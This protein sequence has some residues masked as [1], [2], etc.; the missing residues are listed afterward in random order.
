M[1]SELYP[2]M[3]WKEIVYANMEESKTG[4]ELL[5][6]EKSNFSA[7]EKLLIV[8]PYLPEKE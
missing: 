5:S 6:N 8:S 1:N 3:L 7:L 4:N 2:K